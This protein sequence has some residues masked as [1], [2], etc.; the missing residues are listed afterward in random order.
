MLS[1]VVLDRP[2]KARRKLLP[3]FRVFGILRVLRG[4]ENVPDRS[5]EAQQKQ[6]VA[7]RPRDVPWQSSERPSKAATCQLAVSKPNRNSL[8]RLGG[9]MAKQPKAVESCWEF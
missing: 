6:L 4:A 3:G 1:D 7:R 2:S 8:W 5:F 9:P